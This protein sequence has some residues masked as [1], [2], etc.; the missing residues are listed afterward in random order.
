MPVHHVPV[1]DLDDFV[2]TLEHTRA[3]SVTMVI[4]HPTQ[5]GM[6]LVFT[7]PAGVETRGTP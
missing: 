6:L 1:D 4:S 5:I 7:T 2:D 3:G